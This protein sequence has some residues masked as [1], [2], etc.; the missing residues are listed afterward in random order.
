MLFTA[1][2][3]RRSLHRKDVVVIDGDGG[4]SSSGLDESRREAQGH[5]TP[6]GRSLGS[7]QSGRLPPPGIA[8]MHDPDPHPQ[9][10]STTFLSTEAFPHSAVQCANATFVWMA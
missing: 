6:L 5:G 3:L 10:E 2:G 4:E 8:M 9:V 7:T 1:D